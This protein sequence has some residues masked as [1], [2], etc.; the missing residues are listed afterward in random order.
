MQIRPDKVFTEPSVPGII[1][2]NGNLGPYLSTSTYQT[3]V[4]RDGGITWRQ[5]V[6]PGQETFSEDTHVVLAEHGALLAYIYDKPDVDT[7]FF[8][9]DHGQTF[10]MCQFSNATDHPD[11]IDLF[12]DPSGQTP[13]VF[14]VALV[15][16]THDA[17]YWFNFTSLFPRD[18]T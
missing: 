15:N 18:C 4:S 10:E 3:F 5:V 1:V 17:L 14:M 8:S 11:A 13:Y 2:A 9:L 7:I 16:Q 6:A 12:S